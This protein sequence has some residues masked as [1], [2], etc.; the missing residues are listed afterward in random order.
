MGRVAAEFLL[1]DRSGSEPIGSNPAG[2]YPRQFGRGFYSQAGTK[3]TSVYCEHQCPQQ[4]KVSLIVR[5]VDKN[6][7]VVR[8]LPTGPHTCQ[9]S[10]SERWFGRRIN[11]Q[12]GK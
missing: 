1:A 4:G 10:D 12:A 6:L 2:A 5:A 3:S 11:F 9:C 8:W 7:A